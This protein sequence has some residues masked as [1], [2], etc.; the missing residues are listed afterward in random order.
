[1]VLSNLTANALKFSAP[2]RS[3]WV[4][5]RV[6]RAGGRLLVEV[7]DNGIGI[8]PADQRRVFDEYF[9]VDNHAR[10]PEHGQGLGLSIVRETV[11]R[12][13]GHSIGLAS[14]PGRGTRFTLT[15]PAAD[16]PG[17]T[18]GSPE[19]LSDS[20]YPA[21]EALRSLAAASTPESARRC[22]SPPVRYLAG[23][24]AEGEIAPSGGDSDVGAVAPQ[25][26]PLTGAY[27]LFIEDDDAMRDA[28]GQL[29]QQWGVL[30]EAAASGEDALQLAAGAERTFDVIVSDFRLPGAWDG[31]RLIAE[32]RRLEGV[33]T[34]AI[35]L[36]GEFGVE[37]L[38]RDAP[39]DVQVMA[40]PPDLPRLRGLLADLVH[41]ADLVRKADQASG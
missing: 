4:L 3:A 5:I 23:A 17:P 34:P 25:G 33:R 36:S 10:S 41:Q 1:D 9:Q 18:S 39:D 8:E 31:L 15:L 24:P 27:A 16:H 38:R 7:R 22:E 40:K 6:R 30:V 13:P 2:D 20:R 19:E 11:S 35:L 14:R 28:L 29:L 26:E 21:A 37:T 12:L 32:L